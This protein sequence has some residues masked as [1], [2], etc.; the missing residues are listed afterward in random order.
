[1]NEEIIG[2][3]VSGRGL[4]R[5][6]G[7]PTVNIFYDGKTQGVFAGEVFLGKRE[8]KAAIHVGSKPTISPHGV[9]C[10]AH[11]FDFN[12]EVKFGD[13]VKIKLVQRIRDTKKF[14]DV[15]ELKET[16]VKDIEFAKKYYKID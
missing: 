6:I 7:V 14:N 11:I 12:E 4:G 9:F 2:N 16:I 15:K 8:F 5:E 3:V 1:M 10:E 13:K